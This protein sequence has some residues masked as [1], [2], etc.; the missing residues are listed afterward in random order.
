MKELD[1]SNMLFLD[2]TFTLIIYQFGVLGMVFLFL[3]LRYI[4]VKVREERGVL[5]ALLFL[6]TIILQCLTTNVLEAFAILVMLFVCFYALTQ[7]GLWFDGISQERG[8]L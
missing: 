4:Y 6:G 7:G 5:I 8:E 2:G 3:L 1:E